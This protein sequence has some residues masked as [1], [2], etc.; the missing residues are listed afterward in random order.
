LT[1]RPKAPQPEP[2]AGPVPSERQIFAANLVRF[3]QKRGWTQ[4]QLS[5]VSG[6]SQPHLGTI[7]AL[8]KAFGVHLQGSR[9]DRSQF[10]HPAEMDRR[11]NAG[12]VT[13]YSFKRCWPRLW[14]GKW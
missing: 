1:R 7:T 3:R 11:Q 5:E 8:A 9:C 10:P 14:S 6:V 4:V 2:D 12:V 13:R